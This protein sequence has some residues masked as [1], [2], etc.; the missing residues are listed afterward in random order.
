[1]QKATRTNTPLLVTLPAAD[2]AEL[3]AA[4]E[5]AITTAPG[6]EVQ[7]QAAVRFLYHHRV[8]AGQVARQS[9]Y[10]PLVPAPLPSERLAGFLERFIGW[11]RSH[12]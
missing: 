11:R 7:R 4:G 12:A 9:A 3:A 2:V 5:I 10:A 6:T 8:V 1:M